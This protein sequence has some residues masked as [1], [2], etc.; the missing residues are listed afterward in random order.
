MST[1][2]KKKKK[3]AALKF[4]KSKK[5]Q[6]QKLE[7]NRRSL[8][9]DENHT[10]FEESSR[11]Q[12]NNQDTEEPSSDQQANNSSTINMTQQVTIDP[13]KYL[14]NLPKYD[15]SRDDLYTF[16][17]LVDRV[18]PLLANYNDISQQIFFDILKSRLIGKAREAI[19]INNNVNS[20]GDLKKLFFHS[21]GDRLSVDQLFDELRFLNFKTN[22]FDFFNDIKATLR[23]LNNKTKIENGSDSDIKSNCKTALRIFMNKIP[24]PMK[25]ILCCR[26]PGDLEEAMQI[27]HE[28]GYAFTRV[29]SETFR[30]NNNNLSKTGV[31]KSANSNHNNNNNKNGNDSSNSRNKNNIPQTNKSFNRQNYNNPNHERPSTSKN[32]PNYP[33]YSNSH[34]N[35][36]NVDNT[37][38]FITNNNT[39]DNKNNSTEPMDVDESTINRRAYNLEENE[40]P[41][42]ENFQ[43]R[44]SANHLYPI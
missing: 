41:I 42:V 43:I 36:Y 39:N 13:I 23:R 35:N 17:E 28:T 33:N 27:L 30:H 44:A 2:R 9:V 20:W 1:K 6:R 22:C 38:K 12:K 25:G 7:D 40:T 29:S 14:S 34:N 16:I 19:E 11:T 18:Y 31:N 3:V 8:M 24:E 37:N 10:S 26:N 21:F 15:G 5:D 4:F 32:Y